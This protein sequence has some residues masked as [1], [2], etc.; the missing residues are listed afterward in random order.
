MKIA[1]SLR[2]LLLVLGLLL[3]LAVLAIL[4]S[5]SSSR[6][7]MTAAGAHSRLLVPL[8]VGAVGVNLYTGTGEDVSAPGF[9]AGPV[10]RPQADGSWD[11][12]WFC[13]DRVG[14]A[15]GDTAVLRIACGGTTHAFTTHNP[16]PAPDVAP[17]PGRLVVLSDLEGNLAFMEA[18][19]RKLGVTGADGNW[20][21]GHGQLV[22]LGDAVDRGRDVF[23]VLWRLH[24]L[25]LQAHAAGGALHYV[26]GNHEQYLLRGNTSR[27]HPDYRYAVQQL[28]GPVEAFGPDTLL[29]AWLRT[30]PVI[31]QRGRVLFA[32]AG[33]SPQ[34][35]DTGMTVAQL[36]ATMR[37]YWQRPGDAATP[38]APALDAVIGRTGLTQYR[39]F[40]RAMEDRYPLATS[41]GIERTLAH[42]DARQIVVAHTLVETVHPM[43][44]GRVYAVDVNHDEARPQVLLF[45]DG[46]PGVLDTGVRRTLHPA[47]EVMRTRDF[48]LLDGGDRRLLAA[49]YHGFHRIADIPHPY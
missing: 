9:L 47:P 46:V 11:A 23:A 20:V 42:F 44:E 41:A 6:V 3:A 34:V 27:A 28:G 16:R 17:M 15:S 48:S 35:V 31:L 49:M 32:H 36:D 37:D 30:R 33:I 43:Y 18:A 10:L 7:E 12:A 40:F 4:A 26:L 45:K 25:S 13:E 19:L 1:F 14:K 39:G 29:G 22:V 2:R 24:E 21:Y 8:G 5:L 38:H